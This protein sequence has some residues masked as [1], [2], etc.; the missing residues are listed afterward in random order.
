MY[1][2]KRVKS[3]ETLLPRD[4]FS[5]KDA[6]VLVLA[7]DGEQYVSKVQRSHTD[8]GVVKEWICGHFLKLWE[9][10]V[11]DFAIVDVQKHHVPMGFHRDYQ[12]FHFDRPAFGS[13]YLEGAKDVTLITELPTYRSRKLTGELLKLALFDMLTANIDRHGG[14]YNMLISGNAKP[15]FY[16]IDHEMAMDCLDFGNPPS[17]QTEQESLVNSILFQ[18]YVTANDRNKVSGSINSYENFVSDVKVLADHVSAIIAAMPTEWQQALPNAE[19][20]LRATIFT[21]D[22]LDKTWTTYLSYLKDAA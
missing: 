22:W 15:R 14:H 13:H 10:P 19:A 5:S 3:I 21:D 2:A 20:T 16:A 7:S 1:Q 17:L 11:P 12:P 6:P 9:L 4:V 8:K 18:T